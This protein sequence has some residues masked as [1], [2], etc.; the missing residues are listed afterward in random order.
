MAVSGGGAAPAPATAQSSD[1]EERRR[2]EAA[3]EG[4]PGG[5][6]HLPLVGQLIVSCGLDHIFDNTLSPRIRNGTEKLLGHHP[7]KPYMPPNTPGFVAREMV[8]GVGATFLDNALM[9]WLLKMSGH[10]TT[11]N[12]VTSAAGSVGANV[13][14]AAGALTADAAT[15]AVRGMIFRNFVT[16]AA[17][18]ALD[19]IYGGRI[20]PTVEHLVNKV[21]HV[22][23]DAPK[24]PTKLSS[25]TPL[26]TV[27]QTHEQTVRAFARM[28]TASTS[29]TVIWQ[30]VGSKVAKGLF[31]RY[32][33][34]AGAIA[35][36]FGA[37]L[38]N[39][40]I[41]HAVMWAIGTP[42]C[43]AAQGATRLV[44]KAF[45]MP[46][47]KKTPEDVVPAIGDRMSIA[48]DA[49]IVPFMTALISGQLGSY[50]ESLK[51]A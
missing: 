10:A 11:T 9:G 44:E 23:E 25:N 14:A 3:R 22:H 32:G 16:C 20:G 48:V 33:G 41:N 34:P 15:A 30:L 7:D 36:A 21:F 39:T 31:M 13:G 12:M 26:N 4:G 17:G 47:D 42:I 50:M 35:S 40:M 24:A 45:H 2:R 43:D 51:P 8:Y 19:A 5:G 1:D 46:L 27:K 18:A 29:Y 37:M 49:A 28:F 6:F 38:C